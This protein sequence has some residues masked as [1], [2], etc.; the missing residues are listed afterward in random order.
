MDYQLNLFLQRGN[1]VTNYIPHNFI[2]DA[3]V[4]VGYNIAH[5]GDPPPVDLWILLLKIFGN[6]FGSFSNDFDIAQNSIVD[7][8]VCRKLFE[9]KILG[10]VQNPGAGFENI[11]QIKPVIT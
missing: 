4:V 8:T 3:E 10:V 6:M 5:A 11:F 1:F 9:C 2:V 7:Q